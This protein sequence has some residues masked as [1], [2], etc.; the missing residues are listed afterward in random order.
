[1][2]SVH[3]SKT[4]RHL[5]LDLF[6]TREFTFQRL[7]GWALPLESQY[8]FILS[9]DPWDYFYCNNI[10]SWK[11]IESGLTKETEIVKFQISDRIAGMLPILNNQPLV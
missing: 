5:R 1:M 10:E 11:S 3:T 4:L 6:E 9:V 8:W 2:A 7:L